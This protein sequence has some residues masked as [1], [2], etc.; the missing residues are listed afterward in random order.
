M[1]NMGLENAL[2]LLLLHLPGAHDLNPSKCPKISIQMMTPR[3]F[4][5]KPIIVDC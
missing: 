1:R 3:L 5:A 4:G 2:L